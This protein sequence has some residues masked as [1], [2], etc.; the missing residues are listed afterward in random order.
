MINCSLYFS[1]SNTTPKKELTV[2]KLKHKKTPVLTKS[3]RPSEPVAVL[4]SGKGSFI[5]FE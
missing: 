1:F 3:V 4:L 2:G 5:L